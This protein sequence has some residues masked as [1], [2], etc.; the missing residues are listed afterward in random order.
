M[1][2][3]RFDSWKYLTAKNHHCKIHQCV[4]IAHIG[5]LSF[6]PVNNFSLYDLQI[7]LFTIA[8]KSNVGLKIR[9]HRDF[10]LIF[11]I[12]FHWKGSPSQKIYIKQ[13]SW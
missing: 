5:Q 11:E 4:I 3:I 6:V 13:I 1:I 7:F 2:W 9:R 12:A 10:F 8:I